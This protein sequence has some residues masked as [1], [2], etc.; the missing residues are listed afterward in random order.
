MGSIQQGINQLISTAAIGL[1]LYTRSPAGQANAA[2]QQAER[3]EKAAA[4][5]KTT[6]ANQEVFTG[7]PEEQALKHQ[8]MQA[9]YKS[10]RDS[11]VKS[12]L[13][14]LN[15]N[16]TQERVDSYLDSY[17]N[18]QAEIRE[19][20]AQSAASRSAQAA[21]QAMNRMRSLGMD[22]IKQNQTRRNF[23]DYLKNQNSSLGK[24]GDLPENIQKAIAKSYSA[25][26][27]KKLMDA[28][29]TKKEGKDGRKVSSK[30]TTKE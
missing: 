18:Q 2:T 17:A 6:L 7:T 16:P 22:Q 1:G 12:R 8:G 29:E 23:M 24:I 14:A 9:L 25:A 27:R 4:G 21:R 30:R 5:Y 19:E 15:L 11:A 10:S 28:E 3:A 26:E 20:N 13:Q